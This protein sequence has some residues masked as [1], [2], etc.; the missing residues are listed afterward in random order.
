MKI[1]KVEPE[2]DVCLDFTQR[3]KIVLSFRGK[4]YTRTVFFAGGKM[5][6]G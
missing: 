5:G 1:L 2:P 6:P 3:E 4:F